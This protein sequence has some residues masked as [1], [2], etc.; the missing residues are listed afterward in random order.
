[1]SKSVHMLWFDED[2]KKKTP[3]ATRLAA[4]VARYRNKFKQPP[5]AVFVPPTEAEPEGELEG[6]LVVACKFLPPS[7]YVYTA[8][9]EDFSEGY[10]E[11]STRKP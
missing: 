6:L 8:D 1:M 2:A 9:P 5:V 11:I 3:L 4:P 7:H 10:N